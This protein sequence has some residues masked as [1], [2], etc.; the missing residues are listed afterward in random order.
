MYTQITLIYRIAWKVLLGL[1]EL[2]MDREAWRAAV[3]EVTKS[4]TRLS[5][6]NELITTLIWIIILPLIKG[7]YV[8]YCSFGSHKNSTKYMKII[9]PV[10]QM[11]KLWFR[12]VNLRKFIWKTEEEWGF[13]SFT[14]FTALFC[15][16][17]I[18]WKGRTSFNN[19]KSSNM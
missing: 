8:H 10:L 11:R 18:I 4:W 1:W 19:V 3:H 12:V 7:L 14:W 6:W 9:I 5:D 2:V 17:Y 15:F 16:S 13:Q